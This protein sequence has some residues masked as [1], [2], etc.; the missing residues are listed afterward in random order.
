[1][2]ICM[3][4]SIYVCMNMYVCIHVI[5]FFPPLICNF[6]EKKNSAFHV[7]KILITPQA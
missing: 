6:C 3:C 4:I 2:Y 1:M 5:Y 7:F